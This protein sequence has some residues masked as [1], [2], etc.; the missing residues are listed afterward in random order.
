IE[1]ILIEGKGGAP[2]LVRH[3]A[4]VAISA[5]PRM[6]QVGLDDEDDLVQ[7]VVIMLR[8]ENPGEV[9]GRLKEK[10]A[11]L[12]ERI[13]PPDVRIEPFLDRTELVNA[14]VKT[15][16]RNLVEGIILVS[17][18]VFVFLFNWRTTLIVAIIIPLSFLFAIIM[19]RI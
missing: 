12:N 15:V 6:G 18:I 10:I 13:L 4:E 2:V 16:S 3:V 17:V 19:L 8:G 11:E 7:G 9:I 5:K 1:N 14:T